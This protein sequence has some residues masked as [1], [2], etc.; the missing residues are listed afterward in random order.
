[1]EE[2]PTSNGRKCRDDSD[3]HGACPFSTQVE[4]TS[5]QGAVADTRPPVYS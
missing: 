2:H 1:M 5:H 3:D 4:G